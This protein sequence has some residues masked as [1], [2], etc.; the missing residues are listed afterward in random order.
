M[1]TYLGLW[2]N[3]YIFLLLSKNHRINIKTLFHNCPV[4][5]CF[6]GKLVPVLIWSCDLVF[7]FFWRQLRRWQGNPTSVSTFEAAAIS[8]L[9]D[10]SHKHNW[11]T[12]APP[13]IFLI[14]PSCYRR[15]DFKQPVL[16]FPFAS[17]FSPWIILHGVHYRRDCVYIWP[18]FLFDCNTK[19]CILALWGR[20]NLNV[21]FVHSQCVIILKPH[22]DLFNLCFKSKFCECHVR[23]FAVWPIEQHH[24]DAESTEQLH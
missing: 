16:I 21:A 22:H 20:C 18:A 10:Q 24:L 13:F 4:P 9:L 2:M 3:F 5:R 6:L 12:T 23:I 15:C 7:S 14:T 17:V 1:C 11:Q 19:S 8:Y